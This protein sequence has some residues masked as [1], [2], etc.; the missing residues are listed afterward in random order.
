MSCKIFEVIEN[1]ARIAKMS[2]LPFGGIQVIFTGDFYQLPPVGNMYESD[3]SKFCFESAIWYNVFPMANHIQLKT[4]FRQKDP[5]YIE[6]LLQIREGYITDTNKEILKSYVKR[7][8]NI[9]HNNGCIP[10]KI[11]SVKSKVDFVNNAMFAKLEG[12]SHEFQMITRSN[13]STFTDSGKP[14]ST[15]QIENG[16][17]MN[18][19]QIAYEID[20]LIVNTGFLSVITLKIGA[21]VM[22]TA[23]I[24]MEQSICN[25][26][27]GIIID[28][29]GTGRGKIPIVRFSNGITKPIDFHYIQ[30]EEYPNIAIAQIPL[31]LAWA[32]TI[33]KV[34][35]ATMKLAEM[36][37][38][39]S[40]F[41]YGQIYVALSRVESLEG[42]YLAAFHAHKIKANPIVKE[43]Y[44]RI[45][46]ITEVIIPVVHTHPPEMAGILPNNTKNIYSKYAYNSAAAAGATSNA[47]K[48]E[49]IEEIIEENPKNTMLSS[50]VKIIKMPF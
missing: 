44:K 9:E 26:S 39:N 33:H 3:S 28:I 30:S 10:T 1:I 2:S 38:G 20:Q 34:Q 37:L 15:T 17:N 19:Q 43:F 45:P 11:F 12:D 49:L 16:K 32:M 46:E 35:G 25:G 8:Y 5:V 13:M 47:N 50:S 41:E 22:C 42:L 29:C 24:D 36:D 14:L 4:I 31:T 7:E 21:L 27:Q 6:I 18:I 40:I 23:N 48:D